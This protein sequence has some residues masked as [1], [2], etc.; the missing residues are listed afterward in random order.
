MEYFIIQTYLLFMIGIMIISG[1]MKKHNLL[2]DVFK[3]IFDNVKSKRAVI[4]II[5]MIGGI[6]PIPGR[7]VVSAGILS[8]LSPCCSKDDCNS[9]DKECRKARSKFGVIDYLSTHHY[10]LWSPMEKTVI[11]P[12]AA[13]GIGWAT[14][15]TI[16]YP[17]VLITITYILWYVFFK[18]KE[19]DII[20]NQT[21]LVNYN[22]NRFIKGFLP[23]FFGIILLGFNYPGAYIFTILT[24][25]YL[26]L[27]KTYNI[28][29]ILGYVNWWL[30]IVLS[31]VL[32]LSVFFSNHSD[33]IT[34]FIKT[35]NH[36]FDITTMTGF[37][38]ISGV[39]FMSSWLMGSSGK[40]AG[41]VALL[42]TIY[43]PHY[44]IWFLVLEFFA[45]NVSPSHKCIPI[46]SMY[47]GTPLRRYFEVII[48]WQILLLCYG[49]VATFMIG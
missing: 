41:I 28:R 45:Y 49:F 39:T 25:Y 23:L 9:G 47:F 33:E 36:I 48:Y 20:L 17:L 30:V 34:L 32:M 7:V 24:L 37:I 46:G 26:V 44:L 8:N 2:S 21:F 29:E 35:Y 13:L 10:Y 40:F 27:T 16:V 5:S 4:A 18:L 3:F 22:I 38:A 31:I 15:L 6:L 43:G 14:Y 19:N 11:L 42:V 1:I 12:M